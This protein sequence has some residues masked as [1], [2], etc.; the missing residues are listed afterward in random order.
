MG[1][2]ADGVEG[3]AAIMVGGV[4]FMADGAAMVASEEAPV[5]VFTTPIDAALGDITLAKN[6]LGC[7]R[8]KVPRIK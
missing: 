4:D 5:S 1:A 3:V 6:I 2:A 7:A 8:G